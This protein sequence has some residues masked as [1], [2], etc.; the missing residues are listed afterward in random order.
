MLLRCAWRVNNIR[1]N[2]LAIRSQLFRFAEQQDKEQPK[3]EHQNSQKTE[4]E[5][6]DFEKN[7]LK[8]YQV[9]PFW[10]IIL[11]L[12]KEHNFQKELIVHRK[13]YE[14]STY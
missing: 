10:N 7:L 4:E 12:D 2:P 13:E 8:T 6:S 11:D 9:D 5:F 1:L 14:K 3:Q